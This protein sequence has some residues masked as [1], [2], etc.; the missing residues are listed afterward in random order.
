MKDFVFSVGCHLKREEEFLSFYNLIHEIDSYGFD[1]GISIN[2]NLIQFSHLL[3]KFI[4]YTQENLLFDETPSSNFW[5]ENDD[6]RIESPFLYYGSLKNYSFGAINLFYNSIIMAKKMGYKILHWIEYD[7]SFYL[8]EILENNKILYEEKY[9]CIYYGTGSEGHPIKGSYIA[10]RVDKI[11][12]N[13]PS[14][15]EM[16]YELNRNG[17]SAEKYTLELILNKLNCYEKENYKYPS[18]NKISQANSNPVEKVL[19]LSNDE[20]FLSLFLKNNT[21]ED[22]IFNFF[23]GIGE[24]EYKIE[25]KK[26][27]IINLGKMCDLN[28]LYLEEKKNIIESFFINLRDQNQVQHYI[29]R[30][31]YTSKL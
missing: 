27:G 9:D 13:F 23:T 3:P 29:K 6:F 31:K 24:E 19:F 15:E 17:F 16:I 22:I 10:L 8:D 11:D 14:H 4:V 1:Y 25:S 2:S 20:E 7:S 18:E 12:L 26:W 28:F 30:N 5:F 21:K